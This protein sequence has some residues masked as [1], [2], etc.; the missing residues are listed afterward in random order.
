[1]LAITLVFSVLFV[2]MGLMVGALF[3]WMYREHVLS[4]TPAILHPEFFDTNG[5]VIPDEIIA[6]RFEEP[7][8]EEEDCED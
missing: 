4:Q 2:V 7:E 8:I 6:F 3:G 1:M 5:N